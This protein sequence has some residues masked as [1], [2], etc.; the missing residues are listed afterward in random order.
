MS[1]PDN[2]KV[3]ECH[4]VSASDDESG[5]LEVQVIKCL[6]RWLSSCKW[7]TAWCLQWSLSC[8]S[9]FHRDF[10]SFSF[11]FTRIFIDIHTFTP[12][13]I[14]LHGNSRKVPMIH[15]E[16]GSWLDLWQ[17]RTPKQV[18]IPKASWLP[19]TVASPF[20]GPLVPATSRFPSN[21]RTQHCKFHLPHI[22]YRLRPVRL[23]SRSLIYSFFIVHVLNRPSA[24]P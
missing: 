13:Y 16:V 4:G 12:I 19:T 10:H 11:I 8:P 17:K 21:I 14:L 6:S 3:S 18:W 7:C 23:S 2:V 24:W 9:D 22:R 5:D 1:V 20:Y 15:G